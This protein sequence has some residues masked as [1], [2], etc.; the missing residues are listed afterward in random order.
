MLGTILLY[1]IVGLIVGA[2]ARLILPGKDPIGIVGTIVL[3]IIG[4]VVGG[5]LWE[6]IF[7]EN[8]GVAWIGSLIVAVI[9]L[10]IYRQMSYRRRPTV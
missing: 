8:K 2:L 3:G 9:L 4:A 6:A 1:I 7:G 5:F 10:A